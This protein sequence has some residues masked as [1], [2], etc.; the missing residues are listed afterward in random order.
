MLE[1]KVPIRVS[2]Y[3]CRDICTLSMSEGIVNDKKGGCITTVEGF[4]RWHAEPSKYV[5]YS[6]K[7]S[8]TRLRLLSACVA[9]GNTQMRWDRKPCCIALGRASVNPFGEQAGRADNWSAQCSRVKNIYMPCS[10]AIGRFGRIFCTVRSGCYTNPH[11]SM[12][13]VL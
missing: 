9:S 2:G 1:H 13:N 12:G 3:M 5:S 8:P 7:C 11:D 6:R 4:L 10:F